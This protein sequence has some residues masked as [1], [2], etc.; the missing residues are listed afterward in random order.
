MLTKYCLGLLFTVYY[1][2]SFI[3]AGHWESTAVLCS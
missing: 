2:V 3:V 1:S